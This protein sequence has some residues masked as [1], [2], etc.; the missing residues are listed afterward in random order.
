V[1]VA[2]YQRPVLA[3]AEKKFGYPV[4]LIAG[5]DEHLFDATHKIPV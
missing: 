3:A 4:G 2:S 1:V 5:L